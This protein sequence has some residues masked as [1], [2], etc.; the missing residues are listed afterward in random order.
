MVSMGLLRLFRQFMALAS[1]TQA[2]TP[3]DGNREWSANS[4][5]TL[6]NQGKQQ[7]LV[8]RPRVEPRNLIL[9][10]RLTVPHASAAAALLNYFGRPVC[11][12]STAMLLVL[13]VCARAPAFVAPGPG[14]MTE[15]FFMLSG[16][17]T[18]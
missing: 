17:A 6:P 10:S 11:L 5:P 13:P 15:P 12:T 16:L 7:S 8:G 18:C 1:A 4:I 14:G 9:Y 3:L 2:T